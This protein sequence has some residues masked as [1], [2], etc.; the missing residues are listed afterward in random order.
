[1][2]HPYYLLKCP[3]IIVKR[4]QFEAQIHL[5]RPRCYAGLPPCPIRPWL[6]GAAAPF[7]Y[8]FIFNGATSGDKAA[9][10]LLCFFFHLFLKW[11]YSALPML[12]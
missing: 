10:F 4:E 2:E 6:A 7:L 11:F 1:M 3:S 5:L 12:L 8:H 9:L